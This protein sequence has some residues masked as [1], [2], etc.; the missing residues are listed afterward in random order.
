[1]WEVCNSPAWTSTHVPPRT[2]GSHVVP[3]AIS[4]QPVPKYHTHREIVCLM[5]YTNFTQSLAFTAMELAELT[6]Q[7]AGSKAQAGS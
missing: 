5:A 3:A 6:Q 4:L 1:M 2:S 7:Q